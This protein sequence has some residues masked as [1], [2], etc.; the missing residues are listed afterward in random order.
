M[1]ASLLDINQL[2]A[3]TIRPEQSDF[4][5]NEMFDSLAADFADSLKQK[6]LQ[7]RFIRSGLTLRSDRRMLQ[8]IIRNLLSNAIRYTE[9]GAILVGCRR[10]GHNVRIEVWD[11]GVGIMGEHLPKIFDEYFQGPQTEPGGF[12]LGLAIVQRLGSILGHQIGVRSTPGKGS[13]FSITVPI[14]RV[15]SQASLVPS[16]LPVR[17]DSV[18][19]HTILAIEDEGSVRTAM[20]RWLR[21]Q[22]LDVV[23]VSNGSEALALVNAGGKRFDLILSDYNIP[24]QMNGIDSVC[25]LRAALARKIPAIVLTGDISRTASFRPNSR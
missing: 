14:G 2:E 21:S 6:G 22:G 19:S 16:L 4:S 24:G 15:S 17:P 7:C 8:E 9:E 20:E 1:L 23:S 18:G 12:G 25:A 13:V 3:G 11:S 5:V 10:A